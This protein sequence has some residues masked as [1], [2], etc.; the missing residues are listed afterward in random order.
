VPTYEQQT[1]GNPHRLDDY[2]F[3]SGGDARFLNPILSADV[4]SSRVEGLVFDGL[5][6][7]DENLRYRGRLATGWEVHEEAYF[8]INASARIPG[9]DVTE[10]RAIVDL[11]LKAKQEDGKANPELKAS[12]D[13]IKNILVQPPQNFTKF[14]D[15]KL[16]KKTKDKT[17]TK[18]KVTAPARIKLILHSVDQNIFTNLTRLLGDDYF[19]SFRLSQRK[20][21]EHGYSPQKRKIRSICR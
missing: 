21:R 19:S 4:P 6:D 10:P 17:K 1:R 11:I 16:E 15:I 7:L 3:A 18:F 5:I 12:L 13:N 9:L 2:I 8:F 14:R 20:L